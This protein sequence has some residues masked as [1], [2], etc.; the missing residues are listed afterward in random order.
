M[1][2]LNQHIALLESELFDNHVSLTCKL[3]TYKLGIN[4]NQSKGLLTNLAESVLRTGFF[5]SPYAT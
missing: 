4:A 5:I 1:N 3:L 2:N